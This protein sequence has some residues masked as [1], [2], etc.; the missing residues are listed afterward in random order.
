MSSTICIPNIQRKTHFCENQG[1]LVWTE[2]GGRF[3]FEVIHHG[4]LEAAFTRKG[5]HTKR[6]KV[7]DISRCMSKE[8]DRR[9]LLKPRAHPMTIGL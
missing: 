2:R 6:V 5:A 8:E 7:V 9:L 3:L 4:P 1:V